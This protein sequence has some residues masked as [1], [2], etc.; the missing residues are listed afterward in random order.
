MRSRI[1]IK[2]FTLTTLLCIFILA[3]VFIGH[4]VIFKHYYVYQKMEE[5]QTAFHQYGEDY[6]RANPDKDA[7]RKLEEDFYQK[8]S[9]WITTL[10]GIG[11]PK[12]AEDFSIDILYEWSETVDESLAINIPLHYLISLEDALSEDFNFQEYDGIELFGINYNKTFLPSL[13]GYS[14]TI[15]AIQLAKLYSTELKYFDARENL[16]YWENDYLKNFMDEFLSEQYEYDHYLLYEDEFVP[17]ESMEDEVLPIERREREVDSKDGD[18]IFKEGMVVNVHIPN[19]NDVSIMNNTL[20]LNKMKEFQASLIEEGYLIGNE[21]EVQISD[22]NHNDIQYKLIS[23]SI[24]VNDEP[25]YLLAMTSLQPVDEAMQIVQDYYVY[26]IILVMLLVIIASFYYSK[27]IT[28]PLI[29]LNETTKKIAHL[30]FT[31]RVEVKSKDE[32]GTLSKNINVLSNTLH[33]HINQLQDDIEKEKQLEN[34]RKEFISGV[35]HELKTPLSIMKS[36]I[37]ILKDDVAKH[38]KDYYFQALEQEVEKMN[39]LIIDML[40]LAKYESG[41]Y[42]MEMEPFFIN[43]LIERISASL[44]YEMN[45]KEIQLGKELLTLEV[46][47]NEYRIEQVL[48]NFLTNAIRHTDNKGKITIS[49]SAEGPLVKVSVE[50]T[51]DSIKDEQLKKVWDRFYRGD[52][53]RERSQNETGLGLAISRNILEL[54]HSQYGVE[55][56]KTGVRFYFYLQVHNKKS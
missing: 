23:K 51:G 18:I 49:T 26:L 37:S 45:Q 7:Q 20:F 12:N 17:T 48:T 55:N 50:N 38:K 42:Q 25:L 33:K 46:M 4:A 24:T 41:T 22:F 6:K 30:D 19:Q 8:H 36:T 43:E 5:I 40:D 1:V 11:N 3:T 56:T 2:L 47:A 13:I 14:G 53:S 44:N 29:K 15:E 9:T 54:H 27:I 32:L 10:D 21:S 35:S 34:T 16:S 52:L 28:T 39:R 31:E